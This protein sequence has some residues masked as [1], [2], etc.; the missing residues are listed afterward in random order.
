MGKVEEED[1]REMMDDQ[2]SMRGRGIHRSSIFDHLSSI[3]TIR[4]PESGV[5][6]KLRAWRIFR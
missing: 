3:E 6:C 5:V 4:L 1:L 2:R